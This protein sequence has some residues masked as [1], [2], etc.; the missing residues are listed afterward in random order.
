MYFGNSKKSFNVS[1]SLARNGIKNSSQSSY[2][3]NENFTE[4]IKEV[5]RTFKLFKGEEIIK[6]TVTKN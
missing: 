6:I 5:V 2:Y 4:A 1:V 3:N